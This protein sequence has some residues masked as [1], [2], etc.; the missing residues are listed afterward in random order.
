MARPG[1]APFIPDDR[2][3]KTWL[4]ISCGM[5]FVGWLLALAASATLHAWTLP[6]QQYGA[7]LFFGPGYGLFTGWLLYAT[8]I[9]FGVCYLSRSAPDA[10]RAPPANASPFAYRPSCWAIAFAIVAFVCAATIPD[11]AIPVPLALGLLLFTPKYRAN[12]IASGIAALGVAAG[13]AHVY[14]RRS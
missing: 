12:L 5:L 14:A 10:V 8:G 7:L 11:P 6:G 3:K 4:D 1:D 2:R 9:N 13:A